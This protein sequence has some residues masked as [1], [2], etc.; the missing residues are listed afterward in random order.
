[1]EGYPLRDDQIAAYRKHG[2]LLVEGVFTPEECDEVLERARA[3][4]ARGRIENCFEAV[5]AS[6]ADGDM[7]KVYPRM[8]HPHRVDG[9]FLKY[10]K[11][12][13]VVHILEHLLGTEALGAQSM[14][15]WK[16]PGARGQAFHQDSYYARCEP[17]TCT[18]AWTAL[19]DTDE[20]NGSL[21]VFEGS[22][23]LPI[24][25][26]LP[27]DTA[28]SFTATAVV[29]PAGTTPRMIRMKAGDTLFFGGRVIHGSEPN[30]SRDRFRRSFICHYIA[31][32]T[33]M[34][35]DFYKPLVPLR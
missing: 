28:R 21:V 8:M 29:P 15:Y 23:D 11:H 26:M 33:R 20:G 7:L 12:P 19:E 31:A 4:Y 30:T 22:K 3:L 27:T 18:A 32:D 34:L 24:L 5:P 35:A 17:D 25:D 1:M 16:P 13:R 10:L 6:E 14:F 2:F 9:V